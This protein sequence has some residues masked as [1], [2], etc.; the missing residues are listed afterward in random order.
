M[1]KK[2]LKKKREVQDGEFL[3]Y[4]VGVVKRKQDMNPYR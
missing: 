3:V 2:G 4:F 1:E